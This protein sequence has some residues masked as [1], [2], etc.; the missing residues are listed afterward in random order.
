MFYVRQLGNEIWW[1]GQQAP[2]SPRWT[3]VASGTFD[4][5][6]VRVKWVDVPMGST[7]NQGTL[8]LRVVAA[9]HMVVSENPNDFWNADWFR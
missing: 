6:V 9:N 4:N 3:N 2:N 8:G 5:G 7:R 1:F